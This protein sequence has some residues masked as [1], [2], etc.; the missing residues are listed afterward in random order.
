MIATETPTV[1]VRALHMPLCL[2]GFRRLPI[3][4]Q[5]FVEPIDWVSI[6]HS[7]EHVA[8]VG[9]GFDL[10]HF[11]GFDERADRRPTGSAAIRSG[12]QMILTTE[13]YCPFILPMSGRSWK[14]TTGIIHISAARSWC[15]A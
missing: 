13:G 14:S 3:P 11:G 8:Q 6:D 7:L 15:V 4:R 10:V 1:S 2:D 5:Q 12:E 9:V